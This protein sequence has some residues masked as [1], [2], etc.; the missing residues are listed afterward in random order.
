MISGPKVGEFYYRGTPEPRNGKPRPPKEYRQVVLITKLTRRCEAG[1]C[2]SIV[3]RKKLCS[4]QMADAVVIK[5]GDAF[6]EGIFEQL[7]NCCVG[8]SEIYEKVG[9]EEPV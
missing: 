1:G 4:G 2:F 8:N 5:N 9:D 6:R 3:S 7:Y